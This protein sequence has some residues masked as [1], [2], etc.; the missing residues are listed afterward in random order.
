MQKALE[1]I[2]KNFHK[3]I[4]LKNLL[5]ITSMSNTSFC[6]SFKKTYRMT[7]KEYLLKT[8]VGYACKL[9]GNEQLNISEVAYQSGFENLSNFN[10]QFKNITPSQ[11]QKQHNSS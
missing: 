3:D 7:F 1:F 11:F 5:E 4:T 2:I 6:L 8:R 10:R 9:L